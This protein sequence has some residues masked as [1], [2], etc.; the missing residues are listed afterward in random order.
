MLSLRRFQPEDDAALISWV[1]SAEEL[2]M[3]AGAGLSWPL[4]SAQLELIRSD[5]EMVAYTAEL[6]GIPVGHFQIRRHPP[7]SARLARVIVDPDKRGQ[8]IGRALIQAAIKEAKRR[9]FVHMDLHVYSDNAAARALYAE[10]GFDDHGENPAA[11]ESRLMSK[12]L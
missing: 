4:D 3:F 7:G 8:G 10:L 5:P 9:G 2:R 12:L 11:P 1:R 6:G